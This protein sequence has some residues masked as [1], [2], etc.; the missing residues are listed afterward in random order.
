MDQQP[1]P[2]AP[3]QALKY[4]KKAGV[5]FGLPQRDLTAEEVAAWVSKAQYQ[6]MLDSGAYSVVEDKPATKEESQS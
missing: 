2:G 4:N 5:S 1:A 6:E 3:K